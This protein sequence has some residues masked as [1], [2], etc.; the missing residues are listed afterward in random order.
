[1][2][3]KVH[4]QFEQN[5]FDANYF[6]QQLSANAVAIYECVKDSPGVQFQD[7]TDLQMA[8][9]LRAAGL[10]QRKRGGKWFITPNGLH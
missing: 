5:A 3:T 8:V 10:L 6:Q 7:G 9:T 2:N 1:M 4:A